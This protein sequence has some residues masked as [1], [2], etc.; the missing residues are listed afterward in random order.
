MRINF[1]NKLLILALLSIFAISLNADNTKTKDTNKT[2]TDEEFMKQIMA[3]DQEEKNAKAKT[4]KTEKELEEAKKT[5]KTLD[6]IGN[7]LGVK[8]KDQK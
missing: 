8:Y 4:A 2:M 6:E 1:M 7:L 5:G 3:L